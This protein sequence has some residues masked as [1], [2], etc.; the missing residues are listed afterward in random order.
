LIGER[1]LALCSEHAALVRESEPGT[2]EELRA[3]WT[4]SDGKRSVISRRSPLDRRV[5]P[6]RP[7]GRR[8]SAGRRATDSD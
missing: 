4:E 6:A 5:F 2:L 1:I 7:E 8:R 3:R